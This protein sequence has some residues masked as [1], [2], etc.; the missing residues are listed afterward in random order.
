VKPIT[1]FGAALK[2]KKIDHRRKYPGDKPAVW[3]SLRVSIPVLEL[4]P[5]DMSFGQFVYNMA[6]SSADPETR[7]RIGKFVDINPV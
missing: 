6:M 1:G 3:K 7:K 2:T 5:E 4:K